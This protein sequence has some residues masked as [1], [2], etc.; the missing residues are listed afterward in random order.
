M[1]KLYNEQ[2]PKPGEASDH[3]I[4]LKILE[5]DKDLYALIMRRYNA[6]LYRLGMSIMNNT[7]EVEDA[8]QTVY[9]N[10]YQSLA[11]FSFKSTFST[12]LTRILINECIQRLKKRKQTIAF[13]EETEDKMNTDQ[14]SN[15]QTPVNKM[16]NSELKSVLEDAISKL[17]EKYR[18]VFIM[19]EVE[20]MNIAETQDCLNISAVNV[21]V[22]L[23]R[24]KA[25]LRK[26]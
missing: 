16:L 4:I 14:V 17:P 21:K 11:K 26:S 3:D 7:A 6:R 10:A 13:N 1:D 12:W 5:G 23:N 15:V 22:R 18:I 20:N 8:M 25:L 9:V 2:N 19:R 24:A